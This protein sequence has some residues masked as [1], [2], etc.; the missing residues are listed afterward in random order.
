MTKGASGIGSILFFFYRKQRC[1]G[2]RISVEEGVPNKSECSELGRGRV[3]S[4]VNDA[5]R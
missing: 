5:G 3:N 4:G 1:L 2:A